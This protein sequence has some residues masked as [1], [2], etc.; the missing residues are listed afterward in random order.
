MTREAEVPGWGLEV[1]G[2]TK[3]FGHMMVLRGINLR[4]PRGEF[5]TIFGPNAAGKTTLLKILA[6]VSKPSSGEVRILGLSLKEASI[7]IRR[8]IGVVTH[9][10]LL[11]D[12][13]TVHENLKFYGKMYDVPQL[14]ERID[15]LAG[16][17]G[18]E[19]YFRQRVR[20]LSHGMQKRVSIA[21]AVIHNPDL[22]LL[23]E[24]E[25]GLDQRATEMLAEMLN[26][27]R[28]EGR[29]IVMT[30]HN[31]E[32]GLK[33][34]DCVAILARG[35]LVF[36]EARLEVDAASFQETYLRYTGVPR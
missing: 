29:T 18:L 20:S 23:D 22:V 31:L 7:E 32:R 9:D 35:K 2:L 4:V 17:M 27:L 12:D 36:K 15:Q 10:T 34:G 28:R 19:P 6:T 30:T 8:R 25:A 13:L 26:G 21:R 16:E 5:L 14:G 1:K 24:P 33:M 11:Y 3:S